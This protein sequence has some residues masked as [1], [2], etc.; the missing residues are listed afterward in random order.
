MAFGAH[1]G[2]DLIDLLNQP[3]PVFPVF[4]H[5]FI[6]FQDARDLVVFGF[7]SL[8]P[9]GITVVPTVRYSRHRRD[10]PLS[11][12]WE[13]TAASHSRASNRKETA[14]ECFY[15]TLSHVNSTV[16]ST[17]PLGIGGVRKITLSPSNLTNR[18][19]LPPTQ[20]GFAAIS[21]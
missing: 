2:I 13:H 19:C 4:L 18:S 20:F 8:S 16:R 12:M 14:V 7:F 3:G 9:G 6:G 10:S 17:P 1:Q 5:T 15:L 21:T 11:G